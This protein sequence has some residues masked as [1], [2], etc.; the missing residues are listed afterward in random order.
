MNNIQSNLLTNIKTRSDLELCSKLNRDKVCD[1]LHNNLLFVK[2]DLITDFINKNYTMKLYGLPGNE[3]LNFL[4]EMT[5]IMGYSRSDCPFTFEKKS[6]FITEI[7]YI[8]IESKTK[9]IN[10]DFYAY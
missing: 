4:K 9:E 8:R 6:E 1:T 10:L 7:I 3:I 2:V 5:E